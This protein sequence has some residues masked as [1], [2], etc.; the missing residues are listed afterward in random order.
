MSHHTYGN[1]ELAPE[2]K[3]LWNTYK[4]PL[5]P[6]YTSAF[7]PEVKMLP[8]KGYALVEEELASRELDEEILSKENA[9]LEQHLVVD[10]N[11]NYK[12]ANNN[13]STVTKRNKNS[14]NINGTIEVP[15][16]NQCGL[17]VSDVAYKS[18]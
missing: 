17:A 11:L 4:H 6:S 12:D 2:T 8:A 15:P 5:N 13:T 1:P 14:L 18:D 7:V 10:E 9:I 3:T 16:S